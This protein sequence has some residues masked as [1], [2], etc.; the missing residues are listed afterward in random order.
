LGLTFA[1]SVCRVSISLLLRVSMWPAFFLRLCGAL[2]D[3]FAVLQLARYFYVSATRNQGDSAAFD[4]RAARG[5]VMWQRVLKAL[6]ILFLFIA[7]IGVAVALG[8]PRVVTYGGIGGLIMIGAIV[9]IGIGLRY[10]MSRKV[11]LPANNS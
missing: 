6:P 7:T 4:E 1:A 8:G 2:V 11:R 3:G 5:R 10:F 9:T